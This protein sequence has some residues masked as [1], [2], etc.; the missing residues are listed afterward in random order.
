VRE[1]ST[2]I[3]GGSFFLQQ[4]TAAGRRTRVENGDRIFTMD[5][6]SPCGPDGMRIVGGFH[7]LIDKLIA[8]IGDRA[9]IELGHEV[10]SLTKGEKRAEESVTLR[11]RNGAVIVAR[12]VIVALPPKLV[13]HRI[14][15]F[16]PLSDSQRSAMRATK[17]WMADA[18]KV[19]IQYRR[20]FWLE[21]G[22]SG[23]AFSDQGPL[24]QIWDNSDD[25][26]DGRGPFALA[27]FVHQ[28]L[29]TTTTPIAV[30]EQLVRLFGPEAGAENHLQTDIMNWIDER[31]TANTELDAGATA[32]FCFGRRELSIPAFDHRVFFAGTET[33]NEHGHM[34]GAIKS[35]RRS[36][37]EAIEASGCCS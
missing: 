23:S 3:G 24:S 12:A 17:T 36:A 26:G 9:K 6:Q 8:V 20:P 34:E 1:L 2:A 13:G 35:G 25:N 27:G 4:Q 37:A 5:D 15:F 18:T 7:S 14:D 30:T 33:E 31:W 29:T 32:T 19:V 22:L 10:V 16:P 21:L 11:C 28:G